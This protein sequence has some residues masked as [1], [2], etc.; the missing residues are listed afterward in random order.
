MYE[1][2]FINNRDAIIN[3][4]NIRK[5]IRHDLAWSVNG[6]M[7]RASCHSWSPLYHYGLIRGGN[8]EP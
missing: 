3:E 4:N 5:S 1:K 7:N 8:Y 6:R 2:C